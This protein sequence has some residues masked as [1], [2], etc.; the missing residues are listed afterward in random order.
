MPA[1]VITSEV[2][3]DRTQRQIEGAFSLVQGEGQFELQL[4]ISTIHMPTPA[5]VRTV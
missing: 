1:L 3:S 2:A 5:I 4:E